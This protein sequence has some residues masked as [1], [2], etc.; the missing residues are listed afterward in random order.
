M[1]SFGA[2]IKEIRKN[3]KLTQKM[4]SEDICSQSVLSRIENNEELPNVV[5]M[6]QLC[7]RLGVTIDQIMQFK[8]DEVR[9]LTQMFEKIADYFRH[10]EY[11]KIMDYMEAT[12]IE[13]R[14]HLDTDWQRYYY[15]LGS[16]KFY[17]FNNYEQAIFDLKKGLSYTYQSN[18]DNLSD[19]EIQVISCIGST[20]GSIGKINEAEK[21]LKLSIH[22]FHKLP[23][24][25]VNAELT[26]IFYNYSKFLKD[27]GRLDEAQIYIDQGIVWSRY[28]NSY[29]YLSELFQ[30]KSQLMLAKGIVDKA[31]EYQ[32]LSEEIRHI[33]TIKI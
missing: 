19:F 1:D 3:R 5:V 23:N 24:E 25:R 32:A 7:Q 21:Y 12:K 14:L 26:K 17:L 33:E 13:D 31:K 20:Y 27:Q 15:Y 30:L 22:Y 29:Y 10:K 16:C 9:L 18:K 2:V 28:R 8:S 4:L 6:Q 11:K